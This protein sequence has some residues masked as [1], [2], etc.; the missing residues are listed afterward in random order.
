MNKAEIDM[1]D[2]MSRQIVHVKL[3]R[4]TEFHIRVWLGLKIVELGIRI[5]GCNAEIQD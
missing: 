4:V 3:K 2:L 5:M 1:M